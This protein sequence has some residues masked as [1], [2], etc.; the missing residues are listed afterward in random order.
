[1]KRLCW[2]FI[3]LSFSAFSQE[4]FFKGQDFLDDIPPDHL[5]LHGQGGQFDIY[6][7]FITKNADYDI[8]Y[9][10]GA[11]DKTGR[12]YHSSTAIK[13][14]DDS[15]KLVIPSV[16]TRDIVNNK[17]GFTISGWF[18]VS[19]INSNSTIAYIGTDDKAKVDIFLS[20][21]KILVRKRSNIDKTQMM[22]MIETAFPLSY[23]SYS[24]VEGDITNGY[25]YLAITSDSNS[26]RV[27]L[28][29]PG[30][31]LYSQWFYFSLVDNISRLDNIYF[32][33]NPS[34]KLGFKPADAYSNIMIYKRALSPN[35]T[36]NAFYL[37]S[38]LY[39][40]VSYRFSNN[41]NLDLVPAQSDNQNGNF[42]EDGYYMWKK[43][44]GGN[45]GP[46]SS[47]RWFIDSRMKDSGK[48]IP[49]NLRNARTGGYVYQKSSSNYY[50][51]LL[52]PAENYG[53]RTLFYMEKLE[54]DP[55]SLYSRH[56]QG[57]IKLWSAHDPRYWLGS[58]DNYLYLDDNEKNGRWS[59]DSAIKVYHGDDISLPVRGDNVAL[60][61]LG[62]FSSDDKGA[63]TYLNLYSGS[64]YYYA[65]LDKY[66]VSN[67]NISHVMHFSLR[68]LAPSD[69]GIYRKYIFRGP[70]GDGL[71]QPYYGRMDKSEDDYVI[72][73]ENKD[74][75]YWEVI[76]ID[77]AKL[78][79]KKV[80]DRNFHAIR[81]SNGYGSFLLGR[82]DS[83]C[84]GGTSTCYVLKS[85]AGAYDSDGT[86]K[87]D[88]L[89][90]ID[91]IRSN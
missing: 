28:S 10:G 59:I 66:S 17:K 42:D 38:P 53:D 13:F 57:N 73:Y 74:K 20:R 54:D 43:K 86:P 78:D 11:N 31:R 16:V 35:E 41:N 36:L 81:A 48:F 77:T 44:E 64:S 68:W 49:V 40:G 34:L 2:L 8:Y 21:Q 58:N 62:D 70:A 19:D 79:K 4:V 3:L 29:R 87:K 80:G 1:M 6:R 30:G 7:D 55:K 90:I 63:R 76:T 26:T 47:T 69:Y 85:G 14:A 72:T 91:Y 5:Y 9:T 52:Y 24:P 61:N 84:P 50:Y 56:S 71:L 89:W 51:Q 39:P 23:E 25:F 67:P 22:P 60:R 83:Y 46:L 32:G 65:K 15:S 82:K 33:S 18:Y 37:Q 45:N 27:Y 88:F 75:F 12:N